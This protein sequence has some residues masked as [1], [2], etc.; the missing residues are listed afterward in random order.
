[1]SGNTVFEEAKVYVVGSRLKRC[2]HKLKLEIDGK[3][4]RAEFVFTDVLYCDSVRQDVSNLARFRRKENCGMYMKTLKTM[5][6][7]F[8]LV[9]F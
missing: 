8:F 4:T 7:S 1:M 3:G 2:W 5:R 9:F 6:Q